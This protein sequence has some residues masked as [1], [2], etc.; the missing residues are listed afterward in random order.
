MSY[1]GT[2]TY[3]Y[4]GEINELHF[5]KEEPN[6]NKLQKEIFEMEQELGVPSNLRYHNSKPNQQKKFYTEEEF[7]KALLDINLVNPSHLLMTSNGH[8]E[9]PDGYKLTQKGV[10]Y[11]I[12]QFKRK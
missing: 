3:P 5:L 7:R 8:G 1:K 6:M 2:C 9:F 10:D 4:C 11:I 12:E